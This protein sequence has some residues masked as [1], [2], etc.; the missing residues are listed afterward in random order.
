MDNKLE[1]HVTR[2]ITQ[3]KRPT[4]VSVIAWF[5]IVIAAI[6]L[7]PNTIPLFQNN[8]TVDELKEKNPLTR[9]FQRVSAFVGLGMML[10]SGLGMLNGQNWARW[11]YV[12]WSGFA[13]IISMILFPMRAIIIPSII[14]YAVIVFFLFREKASRYFVTEV[15]WNAENL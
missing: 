5:L 2:E 9:P 7:I 11:L 13:I 1:L 8:Q 6:N 4:S 14:L 12:S 3:K 15:E 10:A